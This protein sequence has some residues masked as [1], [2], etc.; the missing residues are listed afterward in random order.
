MQDDDLRDQTPSET[1]TTMLFTVFSNLID[2]EYLFLLYR[3]TP[4]V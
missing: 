4:D 3:T 2:F 1:M